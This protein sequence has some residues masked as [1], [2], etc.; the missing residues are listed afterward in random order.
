[1]TTISNHL[2]RPP[3]GCEDAFRLDMS[4][5]FSLTTRT[6][7]MKRALAII[8]MTGEEPVTAKAVA[9]LHGQLGSDDSLLLLH[10]GADG[11]RFSRK[12]APL[13]G[14]RYFESGKNLG[15]AGGRNLLLRQPE[16]RGADLIFFIDS[17]ALA[18]S[19][20]LDRMTEFMAATPDTGVAG[21]VV[22]DYQQIRHTLDE[23]NYEKTF[24]PLQTSYYDLDTTALERL[25][26]GCLNTRV[27]DHIGTDPNWDE[28]YLDNQ[29]VAER[30]FR[31]LAIE[32]YERFAVS[33]KHNKQAVRTLN[34][35]SEKISVTNIAGCCQV[36]RG[37]LLREIGDIYDLYSP[38]GHEDVDFCLKAIN[39]GKK[40]Y[41][42]NTTFLIHKTDDRH[43]ARARPQQYRQ[44][45][46]NESRVRTI[47]EYRWRRSEFPAI[48]YNRILRRA[49]AQYVEGEKHYRRIV[50]QMVNEMLGLKKGLIQL[51]LE[52]K[53]AFGQAVR[54]TLERY[55]NDLGFFKLLSPE[56]AK[57]AGFDRPH[58]DVSAKTQR[59]AMLPRLPGNRAVG[60]FDF[61][62]VSK[63][64][65]KEDEFQAR[66]GA[67][68]AA[69]RDKIS[70]HQQSLIGAFRDIHKGQR[71]FIIGN[72]PSLKKVDFNL[73]RD[74]VTIGVNGIFYMFDDIGFAPTYYVVEDNHVIDDN[75]ERVVAF[76]AKA[77]FFPAK[78]KNAVGPAKNHFYLPT[79]WGFY[80]KSS[81]HFEVPRFSRDLSEVAYVGQT[82]TYL[83][84][85][86]AHYMGCSE[87]Y[88]VG[89]DFDYKVP[90]SSRIDGHTILSEEDDPNHFHPEYFGKGK[91][92]HF[93][94]LENCEKVYRHARQIYEE[95]GRSVIDATIG[96]KLQVYEKAEFYQLFENTVRL[97]KPNAPLTSLVRCILMDA[98][99]APKPPIFE[100]GDL[101][102][103]C[104]K[105]DLSALV[106]WYSGA[107][108]GGLSK[109][110]SGFGR[111]DS[112][113][114]ECVRVLSANEVGRAVREP[115]RGSQIDIF[116]ETTPLAKTGEGAHLPTADLVGLINAYE[117]VY[118]LHDI[119]VAVNGSA[120]MVFESQFGLS[121][122]EGRVNYMNPR[123]ALALAGEPVTKQR[124]ISTNIYTIRENVF[125][126]P[127]DT[128]DAALDFSLVGALL[129]LR[130]P[131]AIR[132][133]R[134]YFPG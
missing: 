43:A 124:T 115:R 26:A 86:L 54:A 134:L 85:Q 25:F 1:L 63:M 58:T 55:D 52:E 8:F 120:P 23:G 104:D 21:P 98:L 3:Q 31:A 9:S 83:N 125:R 101:P 90:S 82:V 132:N 45:Q 113:E 73:L 41:T 100:L 116:A 103:Y 56:A 118:L 44:K 33:L 76:P 93:P 22:L 69:R 38:Y 131:V 128:D 32:P 65:D 121:L 49:F 106:E 5:E 123:I 89:V 34:Q 11:P 50:E 16:C 70:K 107:V 67:Y 81:P 102:E 110:L 80:Y 92:W 59:Q 66:R 17:D 20:Y 95:D 51:A 15:V 53:E 130:K 61:L 37:S 4:V 12:Y 40:N 39:S 117:S 78:Y 133:K 62:S 47:L 27:L 68:E 99:H 87:V 35:S 79:D 72:G 126:L 42:T 7:I 10:N 108:T 112:A 60:R 122:D 119:V 96:G 48:C 84:L 18:P 105:D 57:A 2:Q 77:K 114:T 127:V 109:K 28:A 6:V 97:A 36:F 24:E 88:L 94:K 129:E 64:L 71:C 13:P 14:I 91:K 46:I 74:E 30:M 29:D 111:D 75:L 19:D